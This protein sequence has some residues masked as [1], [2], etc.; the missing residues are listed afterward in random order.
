MITYIRLEKYIVQILNGVKAP[1]KGFG[2]VNI[3]I[4]K[5]NIIVPL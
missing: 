3:K 2:I 1:A 4:A 5:I